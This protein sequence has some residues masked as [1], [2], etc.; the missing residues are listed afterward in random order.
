MTQL[1]EHRD[2]AEFIHLQT[3]DIRIW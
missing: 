3:G 1:N 2:L